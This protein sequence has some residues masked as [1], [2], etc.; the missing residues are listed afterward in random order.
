M[1]K[2]YIFNINRHYLIYNN[3]S[4]KNNNLKIISFYKTHD[5]HSQLHFRPIAL[6]QREI[7]VQ[8]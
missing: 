6:F 3:A 1:I 8:N 4:L 7:T 5:Q 2:I